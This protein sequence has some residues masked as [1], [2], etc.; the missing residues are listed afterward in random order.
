MSS[1]RVCFHYFLPCSFAV[2]RFSICPP[3]HWARQYPRSHFLHTNALKHPHFQHSIFSICK[4]PSIC[5][6][7]SHALPNHYAWYCT[8]TLHKHIIKYPD[9]WHPF[10]QM[11]P[12]KWHPATYR[13]HFRNALSTYTSHYLTK[14]STEKIHQSYIHYHVTC[15]PSCGGLAS[16]QI[17]LFHE[18]TTPEQPSRCLCCRCASKCGRYTTVLTHV[19]Y[20]ISVDLP[21]PPDYP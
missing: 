3:N 14:I 7:F 21:P 6:L 19:R 10:K 11:L 5:F 8:H 17:L 12:L 2:F 9:C 1:S 16:P 4:V 20:I 13:I 18:K 15:I